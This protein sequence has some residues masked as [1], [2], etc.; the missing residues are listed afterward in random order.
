MGGEDSDDDE[1]EEIEVPED[2]QEN[3]N[4]LTRSKIKVKERKKY[5]ISE[6]CLQLF[7]LCSKLIQTHCW[8]PKNIL[9]DIL[10]R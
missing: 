10:N 8:G 9:K 3:I 1:V 2:Q 4:D 7:S 5:S 6:T